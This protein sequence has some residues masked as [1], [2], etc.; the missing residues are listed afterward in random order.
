MANGLDLGHLF[1]CPSA[2][3]RFLGAPYVHT[4][5]SNSLASGMS[6]LGHGGWVEAGAG[7]VC[8]PL[9]FGPAGKT[10]SRVDVEMGDMSEA[11]GRLDRL[12]D[13]VLLD[14]GIGSS[15]EW[16]CEKLL[17]KGCKDSDSDNGST[18]GSN[19]KGRGGIQS[20][21]VS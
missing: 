19:K 9:G 14:S 16:T 10:E 7:F 15:N 13:T 8:G 18:W 1:G 11:R 2:R 6:T 3:R 21:N 20:P 17:R 4:I 12:P 5:I